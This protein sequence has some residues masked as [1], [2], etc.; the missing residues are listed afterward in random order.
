MRL[1]VEIRRSYRIRKGIYHMTRLK[2]PALRSVGEM[3]ILNI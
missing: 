1:L 2:F 3:T